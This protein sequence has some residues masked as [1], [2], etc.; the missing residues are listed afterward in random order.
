MDKQTYADCLEH[1]EEIFNRLCKRGTLSKD[2][3]SCPLL[4]EVIRLRLLVNGDR[5]EQVEREL[6]YFLK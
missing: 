5:F 4:D 2:C 1:I 6:G 3:H